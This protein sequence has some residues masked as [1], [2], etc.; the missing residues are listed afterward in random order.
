MRSECKEN[1]SRARGVGFQIVAAMI[2][3]VCVCSPCLA[4]APH[5]ADLDGDWTISHEE[6]LRVIEMWRAGEYY[7]DESWQYMPGPKPQT[8]PLQTITVRL[9]ELYEGAKPLELVRIP[10]GTFLMGSKD[11]PF[12]AD[13]WYQSDELPQHQV[14]ITKDFYIGKYEVT[15][16]QWY[17][18]MRTTPSEFHG[19]PD[20]PVETVSWNDC[21]TFVEKL[22]AMDLVD[23]EFRL[24]TE[25]EWEY[26]CRAGTTTRFYWGDSDSES[27]MKQYCWYEKNAED[28]DWTSPHADEE[29][30]QPVGLKLPN[31]WGLYDMSG[32]VWEWCQD[33]YGDY[34]LGA[35]VDPIGQE[36]GS[37]RVA[38]GGCWLS[39]AWY[40]RSAD[41]SGCGP[42]L[43][44]DNL[45]F[46]LVLSRTP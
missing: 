26:A 6:L 1:S 37:L 40:C 16:A 27:V 5:G 38:R 8:G 32:N 18:V 24:P 36:S 31:A 43:T 20:K 44:S 39:Y 21:Q 41:R 45:G 22:N 28:G 30:T 7:V 33:W 10:A 23:G 11:D 12:L 19:E 2:L 15:Q 25:A 46:R 3:L 35:V 14:T 13:A 4:Q 34:P 17:A 29:G 42:D 9:P